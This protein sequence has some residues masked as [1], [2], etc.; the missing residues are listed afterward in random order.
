M[1]IALIA[2]G[3]LQQSLIEPEFET[4]RFLLIADADAG[5]LVASYD[6]TNCDYMGFA[7]K[8]V[9]HDC[10]AVVCGSIMKPAFE[11]IARACITRYRGTGLPVYE[12]LRRAVDGTLEII[13]EYEGG[14]GCS[15]RKN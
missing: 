11:V 2:D 14:P 10:E 3:T 4:G 15:S 7:V 12:A 13:P 8:I 1:Y 5:K 9:E 6:K